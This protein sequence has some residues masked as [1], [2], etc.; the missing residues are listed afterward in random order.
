[1]HPLTLKL[2][3]PELEGR[4][5]REVGTPAY[6]KTDKWALLFSMLKL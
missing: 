6:T 5:W 3:P 4:F 1:M 2:A